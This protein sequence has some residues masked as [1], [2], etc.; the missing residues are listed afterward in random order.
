MIFLDDRLGFKH[1]P[2]SPVNRDCVSNFEHFVSFFNRGGLFMTPRKKTRP[3]ASRPLRFESLEKRQV[4]AG[5]VTAL[6]SGANLLITGDGAAN[7]ILVEGLPGFPGRVRITPQTNAGGPTTLNGQTAALIFPSFGDIRINLGNGS[8]AL[9]FNS[10][11]GVT[12]TLPGNLVIDGGRGDNDISISNY[13]I[14]GSL[15]VRNSTGIDSV[16]IDNT[17][18]GVDINVSSDA[19][20][21][22]QTTQIQ[23]GSSVGRDLILS[24]RAGDNTIEI[25]DV[26]DSGAT[27]AVAVGRNLA[28]YNS[29][30]VANDS[31]INLHDVNIAQNLTITNLSTAT[32]A[33]GTA[34]GTT[35]VGHNVTIRNGN[36]DNSVTVQNDSTLGTTAVDRV[37]IWNGSGDDTVVFD[38]ST[39]N[40]Q[41]DIRNGLGDATVTT[42]DDAIFNAA[43]SIINGNNGDHTVTIESATVGSLFVSNGAGASNT[44]LI[45]TASTVDIAG[46]T[47]IFNG[48]VTGDNRIEINFATLGGLVTLTNGTAG[49]VNDIYVGTVAAGAV[50][51]TNSLAIYNGNGDS[52]VELDNLDIG[53]SLSVTNGSA[54]ASHS[55]A[56]GVDGLVDVTGNASFYLTDGDSTVT[57]DQVNIG[58]N[59]GLRTGAGDD[60]LVIAGG[61]A[62]GATVL[63]S[64][65]I[66]TNAGDDSLTIGNDTGTATLTASLT[67]LMGIGTDSI[68]LGANTASGPGTALGDGFFLFDGGVDPL[69]LNTITIDNTV[70]DPFVDLATFNKFRNLVIFVV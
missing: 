32:I 28:I 21:G 10:D 41:V 70:I 47:T 49:G 20:T 19:S 54:T 37:A 55:L 62:L 6:L 11:P 23:G 48:N 27:A 26:G 33:V 39:S 35:N 43:L 3:A 25:G 8:D 68:T 7:D 16:L 42:S 29:G 58:G 38:E 24:N 13:T 22:L 57:L 60:V 53:G 61:G 64:T 34:T 15:V 63:G 44:V 56:V 51:T 14:G 31:V 46:R 9:E 65:T 59:L 18:V 45:G 40:A 30:V 4:L 52:D 1:N 12:D 67:V 50:T 66:L 5:N 17:D 2:F 36:G 69:G